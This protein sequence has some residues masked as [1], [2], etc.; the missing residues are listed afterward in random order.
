MFWTDASSWA[1][2]YQAT[3]WTT[4][5]ALLLFMLT[6]PACGQFRGV[7]M[8]EWGYQVVATYPH[9]ETSFTQGLLIHDGKMYEGTGLYG[10]SK[11]R[12]VDWLTGQVAREV[13]VDQRFFGEGI[14]I[15]DDEIFQLT[16]RN[17]MALVYSVDDFQFKRKLDYSGEGWG[18]TH[19]GT[20]FI[21][22]DGTSVLRFLD[23]KT[24]AVV[25]KVSV[26]AGKQ[27]IGS[28]N[29]LE[30]VD[31]EIWSNILYEDRIVRV[32]PKDGRVLGWINLQGLYPRPPVDRER[33]LN[34]IAY[35]QA[36]KKIYVTGKNWP[37]LYEIELVKSLKTK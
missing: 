14:A 27:K 21:L 20:H 19:D 35:D 36:T 34:G 33:V 25:R 26:Q 37:N 31:G 18:L 12:Q 29:E 9:D 1:G 2:G 24:F 30:Y 5:L 6:L 15:L 17:R 13:P 32:S 28:L 3:K 8:E 11:L 22:S 23:S 16:W 10:R 4:S 7:K